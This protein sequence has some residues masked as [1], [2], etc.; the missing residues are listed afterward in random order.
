[1]K[2]FI[3]V[4]RESTAGVVDSSFA[5]DSL[6]PADACE[7][8]CTPAHAA[9]AG[10]TGARPVRISLPLTGDV[11]FP[12]SDQAEAA[13][14]AGVERSGARSPRRGGDDPL[15]RRFVTIVLPCGGLIE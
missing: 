7:L 5:A 3:S 10:L 8:I 15:H 4:D 12:R 13:R 1:M 14:V 9:I 2:V 11:V 6:Q